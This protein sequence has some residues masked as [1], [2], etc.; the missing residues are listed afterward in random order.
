MANSRRIT[1]QASVIPTYIGGYVQPTSVLPGTVTMGLTQPIA[2]PA[3]LGQAFK[4]KRAGKN[5]NL[6]HIIFVLDESSSMSSCWDQTISGYNEYLKAQKEDAEK[7]GIKTLV[8][9]YK[10]NGYDVRAIFDRQDVAEVQP[11]DK[12]NYRPS[13]GTNLLDAM[14]G[15]MM[16]IN[17]ILAEKKKADRESVIITVLTDGE[18]NQ[19]RTFRNDDIKAMVEKSEGKNWGFMFLGANIDAFHAGAAMGFN[20]NNTMQFSTANAAETF[21]SASAMTSRMKGDYASGM[22]TM[23]SY[24]V[25]AFNDAER[26]AAV[27]DT[28][29]GK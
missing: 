6:S 18:E 29:A 23:D 5:P 3:N 28:D 9:L 19:S 14:G 16:K 21:R 20:H 25:S 27:G 7:T 10:F 1:A 17:S 11:L 12:N 15:V 4:P 24:T 2:Q 13:G 8:S 26:K 22:A